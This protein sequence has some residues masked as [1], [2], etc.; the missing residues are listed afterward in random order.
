M[1]QELSVSEARKHGL[2]DLDPYSSEPVVWAPIR[3]RKTQCSARV[4]SFEEAAA[5]LGD[6]AAA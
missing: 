5:I 2:P 3:A 1:D 4:P 6:G